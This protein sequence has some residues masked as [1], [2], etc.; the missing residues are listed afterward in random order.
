MA[1]DNLVIELCTG[2]VT[3][4][5]CDHNVLD[6]QIDVVTKAQGDHDVIDT[7]VSRQRAAAWKI[8]SPLTKCQVKLMTRKN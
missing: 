7:Q 5:Q 3:N 8:E 2:V 1:S 6:F 4:T